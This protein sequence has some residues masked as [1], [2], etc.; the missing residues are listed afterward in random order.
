MAQPKAPIPSQLGKYEVLDRI[1]Y[2]G[3]AE[4]FLARELG[5]AGLERLVVIKRILPQFASDETFVEMFLQEARFVARLS[6]PNVVQI[7]ELGEADGALYIAMEYIEG[8]AVRELLAQAKRRETLLPLGAALSIVVQAC[9]GA[10]AAHELR[11]AKG[12]IL[13]LVHRDI[14]PHNLMVTSAGFVKLLDFGIAKSTEHARELTRTGGLKGKLH[15]LSPEQCKRERLDRRSDVFAIG[16]VASELLTGQRLF[17]RDSELATMQAIV[18]GKRPALREV[19]PEIPAAIAAVIEKSLATEREARF[20]SADAMRRALIDAA[21][22]EGVDLRNDRLA[23]LVQDFTGEALRHTRELVR[24]L[25]DR[26][27][28]DDSR[29][30]RGYLDE[31]TGSLPHWRTGSGSGSAS[32]SHSGHSFTGAELLTA[33]ALLH[34][35]QRRSQWLRRWSVRALAL[36]ISLGLGALAVRWALKPAPLKGPALV[37]AFAPALE[38][39]LLTTELEPLRQYLEHALQQPVTF[40]VTQN[41]RQAGDLIARGEVPFAVLPPNLYIETHGQEPLV[42]PVAAGR[43]GGGRGNDGI[44]LVREGSP[45]RKVK[46]LRGARICYSDPDSTTG[47]LFPR[48]ALRKAGIDPDKDLAGSR[49]SGNH[50]QSMRDL[51]AGKCDFAGTFSN[52]YRTADETGIEVTTLRVL[53]I[54]GRAPHDAWCSGPGTDPGQVAAMRAALLAFEP[55]K[56][57]GRKWLGDIQRITAYA[58]ADDKDYTPLRKAI[59]SERAV[60]LQISHDA[61]RIQYSGGQSN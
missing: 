54:T 60:R 19:Q 61:G 17:N 31:T 27:N 3:M 52:A 38:P 51:I 44:L 30:E 47:Y 53:D 32:G 57:L 7:H 4:I 8:S 11:D 42:V 37:V 48:A 50:L 18:E 14:T 9:E 40:S 5:L 43:Y 16:V 22:R 34:K 58:P 12:E 10:H 1:A 56:V 46:D 6:H 2:G 29:L 13:G 59:A 15:Y 39:S 45:L 41:Y 35:Q 49:I 33:T 36:F 23:E 21:E 26:A 20:D 25:I 28:A 55:E 24:K